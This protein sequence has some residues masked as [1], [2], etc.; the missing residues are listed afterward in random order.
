M[1]EDNSAAKKFESKGCNFIAEGKTVQVYGLQVKMENG[2][3]DVHQKSYIYRI[4]KTHILRNP[5]SFLSFEGQAVYGTNCTRLD[6]A[7]DVYELSKKK[8]EATEADSKRLDSNFKHL[9]HYD[10]PDF[11]YQNN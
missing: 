4:P 2:I 1:Y 3:I 9:K 10:L 8:E 6:L 11:P 7:F 5:E